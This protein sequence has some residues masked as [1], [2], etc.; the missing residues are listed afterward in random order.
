MNCVEQIM[1]REL[2]TISPFDSVGRVVN[3]ME[4]H[5]IGGLPVL[6]NKRLVGIITS[7]D[8]RKAHPN[9]LVA[10]A[11][12][13]EVVTVMP[14]FSLWQ[15]KELMENHC[16]ER[17]V[18]LKEDYPVGLITK[19]GLI[20]EL[21]KYTDALTGLPRAEFLYDKALEFLRKGQEIAI[22][23]L[24]LDDFG[25][26]DKQFGH[27]VGDEIL[28]QMAQVLKGTTQDKLDYLCRYAGDEFAIVTIRPWEDA[29]R[30]AQG[31]VEAISLEKWPQLI[32]VK[33]SAGVVG[34]QI[35]C[36]HSI[37]R[38][39]DVISDLFNMASLAST[40]AKKEEGSIVIAGQVK[41]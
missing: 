41:L 18:V 23:F 8:V 10:D 26:I 1:I 13:R 29:Q 19:S 40:K 15:A 20:T 22:I 3:V 11:M 27:V 36:C 21:G 33:G 32:N 35:M 6:E 34:S 39:A 37:N 30:L 14:Q 5:K 2:I 17:L 12:S 16:I 4:K 31:I 24:D 28:R 25:F 7:R 9:R 38:E